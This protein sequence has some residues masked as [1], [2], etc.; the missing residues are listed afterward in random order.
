MNYHAFTG[1][2]R[3][4]S[5]EDFWRKQLQLRITTRLG[6]YDYDREVE[7]QKILLKAK[8]LVDCDKDIEP[9]VNGGPQQLTIFQPIQTS[10]SDGLRFVTW[11][12]V[13]QSFRCTFIKQQFHIL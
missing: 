10:F 5:F 8:A 7:L 2:Y 9:F 4:Q 1:Y 12:I 3:F 13:L 6:D 11:E